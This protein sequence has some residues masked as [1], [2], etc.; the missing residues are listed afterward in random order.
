MK[1]RKS[2]TIYK[3]FNVIIKKINATNNE[4]VIKINLSMYQHNESILDNE[5]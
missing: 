3:F 5:L 4:V 1:N 2:I